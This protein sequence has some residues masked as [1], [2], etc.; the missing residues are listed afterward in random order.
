M[1][2]TVRTFS[3][4]FRMEIEHL[5]RQTAQDVCRG[6]G[7]TAELEKAAAI[8]E[9]QSSNSA[10]ASR[11]EISKIFVGNKDLR[12]S[13]LRNDR[14]LL[15]RYMRA[16]LSRLLNNTPILQEILGWRTAG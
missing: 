7:C 10:N 8:D 16:Y 14:S 5:I 11:K 13:L 3:P 4:K 15:T 9:M 6:Y 2:G 12:N 1:D